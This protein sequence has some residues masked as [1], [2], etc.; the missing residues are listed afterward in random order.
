MTADSQKTTT[1]SENFSMFRIA[2]AV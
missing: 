1:P 2:F